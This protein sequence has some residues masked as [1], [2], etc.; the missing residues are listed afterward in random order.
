[1]TMTAT[2]SH[3]MSLADD[4]AGHVAPVSPR[5]LPVIRL[6]ARVCSVSATSVG[7]RSME[8]AP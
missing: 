8:E 1:M 6:N 7:R 5:Q 3:R 4:L 2:M